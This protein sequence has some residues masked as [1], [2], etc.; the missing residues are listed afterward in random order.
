MDERPL[1]AQGSSIQTLGFRSFTPLILD[2]FA[3]LAVY[4]VL[5]RLGA[6]DFISLGI[7]AVLPAIYIAAAVIRGRPI[8]RIAILVLIL[9]LVAIALTLAT[10]DP[11]ILLAK[12]VIITGAAGIYILSTLFAEHS[13]IFH[14]SQRLFAAGDPEKEAA[15]EARWQNSS[16]FR[17]AI[18]RLTLIWGLG[19]I[20]EAV[21]R[22]GII[23]ALPVAQSVIWGQ[24]WAI[25]VLL[26]L[27]AI[28]VRSARRGRG[29]VNQLVRMQGEQKS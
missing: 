4:A 16:G 7:A 6:N 27:I 19:L 29:Q 12:S 1:M 8:D 21:V 18:R 10:G 3:P 28:S 9:L 23:Y 14:A 15:W 13:F 25:A 26:A 24:V 11:R 22:A 17:R 20:G 2:L 5:S